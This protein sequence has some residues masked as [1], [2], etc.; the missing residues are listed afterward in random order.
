VRQE[1]AGGCTY[2]PSNPILW[3]FGCACKRKHLHVSLADSIFD[4]S[5]MSIATIHQRGATS[6][7]AFAEQY[8]SVQQIAY[9]ETDCDT[10]C[11]GVKEHLVS[12]TCIL[13][14]ED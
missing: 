2:H 13:S 11:L 10:E 12:L 7:S 9:F 14:L 8:A 5:Q 6:S 3:D 4:T 1:E